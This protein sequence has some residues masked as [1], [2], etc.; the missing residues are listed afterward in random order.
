MASLPPSSRR[1]KQTSPSEGFGAIF[2]ESQPPDLDGGVATQA[3]ET[4]V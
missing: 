3:E 4:H 2:V 1:R